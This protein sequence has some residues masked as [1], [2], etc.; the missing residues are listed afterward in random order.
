MIKCASSISEK[1]NRLLRTKSTE[2]NGSLKIASSQCLKQANDKL[3]VS[4]VIDICASKLMLI[5]HKNHDYRIFSADKQL[6]LTY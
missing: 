4:L 1:V 5:V 3:K 2:N 6:M